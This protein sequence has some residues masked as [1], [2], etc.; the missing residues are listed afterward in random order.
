M[1]VPIEGSECCGG[2]TPR[3]RRRVVSE[4]CRAPQA[5]G[6]RGQRPESAAGLSAWGRAAHGGSILT[7]E[8]ERWARSRGRV[9][10]GVE[11]KDT[12]PSRREA[13]GNS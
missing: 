13:G 3:G 9:G 5:Q 2:G 11:L 6:T 10:V 4:D 1:Q 12:G 8:P 7:P